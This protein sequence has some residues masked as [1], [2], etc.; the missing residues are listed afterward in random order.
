ML[1]F[2]FAL[3][4]DYIL[5]GLIQD[6]IFYFVLITESLV[7]AMHDLR[8]EK[9]GHFWVVHVGHFRLLCIGLVW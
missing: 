9:C 8:P 7:E 4:L 6:F 1:F 3:Y 5:L 2:M